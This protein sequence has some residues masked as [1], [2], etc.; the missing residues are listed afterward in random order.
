M[1]VTASSTRCH[2]ILFNEIKCIIFPPLF[3]C[4]TFALPPEKTC[5]VCFK[6]PAKKSIKGV[7]RSP[8]K[9]WQAGEEEKKSKCVFLDFTE[10]TSHAEKKSVPRIKCG[11]LCIVWDSS[12]FSAAFSNENNPYKYHIQINRRRE[13]EI[14]HITH[15]IVREKSSCCNKKLMA[16][17]NLLL[18][19][20]WQPI[21]GAVLRWQGCE[22]KLHEGGCR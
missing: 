10:I 6:L 3:A 20:E 11:V 1:H 8:T 2:L 18:H 15:P 21:V 14:P 9:H 19:F 12:S 5:C 7:C 22:M 13:R 17:I 4:T 16:I